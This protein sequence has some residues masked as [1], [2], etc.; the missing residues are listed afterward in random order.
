MSDIAGRIFPVPPSLRFV[1]LRHDGIP[2]PHFDLM[3][4]TSPGSS[5]V[6][7]RSARWPID[8]ETP[9]VRI[10]EHR[11]SYLDYQGPVSGGRG[12][13]HRVTTGFYRLQQTDALWRLTFRDLIAS[14]EL[15]FRL[16]SGDRWTAE[17][18][19]F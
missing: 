17:P 12:Q 1:V 9:L 8:R 5:L 4:E 13:V 15:V 2:D 19:Q 6:T 3:F 7:W 18:R 11:R 10:A 16:E 14:S